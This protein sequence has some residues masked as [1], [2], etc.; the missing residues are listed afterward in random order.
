MLRSQHIAI[1]TR[2]VIARIVVRYGHQNIVLL[3]GSESVGI[4]YIVYIVGVS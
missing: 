4:G 3:A 1:V 2:G